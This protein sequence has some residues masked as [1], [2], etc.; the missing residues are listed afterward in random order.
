[1]YVTI[2]SFLHP[3]RC[4]YM[5]MLRARLYYN[6]CPNLHGHGSSLQPIDRPIVCT[7][8]FATRMTML[9]TLRPGGSRLSRTSFRAKMWLVGPSIQGVIFFARTHFPPATSSHARKC[10]TVGTHLV[11]AYVA[12]SF[13]SRTCTYILLVVE[14]HTCRSRGAQVS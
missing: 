12:L 5:Y 3:V 1:M 13:W 4:T 7:Y 9:R 2:F 6:T 8:M 10:L 14:A 11:E